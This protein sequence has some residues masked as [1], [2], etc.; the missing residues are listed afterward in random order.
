MKKLLSLLFLVFLLTAPAY[1]QKSFDM[2]YNEAVEYYTAKQYDKA[3]KVLEAAK[4]SPGVTK[5]Q[6]AKATRLIKQCQSSKQKMSDLNLSKETI[7]ASG[8]GQR[9]SIYVTAGK[10]WEVTA[11]PLWCDTWVNDDVLFIEVSPNEEA[12]TRKGIIEVSMGKERTAYLTVNQEKRVFADCPVRIVSMP[13][14]AMITIDNDPSMLSEDFILS[15]GKHRIRLE[16]NGYERKDTTIVL[17][18]NDADGVSFVIPLSPMFS[19]VSIDVKPADG[20][21]FEAEPVVDISGNEVDLHPSI[22]KSFNVDQ[23]IS[24]YTMY[25]GDV[26]PLH[27]GQYVVKARAEGFIAQKQNIK[28]ERGKNQKLEFV[29][30]P[31]TG[32]LSVSDE[33]NAS[34]A[35]VYVDGKEVGSVPFSGVALKTGKHRVR[36]VKP[37][38]ITDDEEYEVEIFEG[39]NTEHKVSMQGYREYKLSS[40]PAYCKIYMDGVYAG[41]TPMDLIVRDGEHVLRIEKAGYFPESRIINTATDAQNSFNITLENAYPFKVMADKDSLGILI[42]KGNGRNQIVYAQNVKTPAEVQIP[43]SKQPY[44]IELKRFDSKT[45]YKGNFNFNKQARNQLKILTWAD[46]TP[47]IATNV[48]VPFKANRL[49]Y[50][51]SGVN[52]KK[53]YIRVADVS[54]API[55]LFP[56]LTTNLAKATAFWGSSLIWP[57]DPERIR[58]PD[59]SENNLKA[60]EYLNEDGTT[61]VLYNDVL[62]I[63][64]FTAIL[65]NGELRIGGAVTSFM[66]AGLSAS[67]AWYPDL[68]KLVS[69]FTHMSG[70]DMF[71][72]GEVSSRLQVVNMNVKAGV[73]VFWGQAN[74]SRP[75]KKQVNGSNYYITVPYNPGLLYSVS[76]GFTL[77]GRNSRGQNFLRVF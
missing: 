13:E 12:V 8:Q 9:D 5:D 25:D 63:P 4:K 40:D 73:Q 53:N 72:G 10:D 45:V 2:R 27:P 31:V 18:R 24:Y 52:I 66:D 49:D 70:H 6:V 17:D 62:L 22:I 64:A 46:G 36:I 29:L 20:Y 77:G 35:L 51:F 15:E 21:S 41:T 34:G 16:K 3:I 38:F 26:I 30:T 54:L 33:E 55:R 23:D 75:D 28:A 76:V 11:C 61:N 59:D 44:Q 42:T 58:Y 57:N 71:I 50:G 39:K 48:Y 69:G 37:D 60:L 43:L 19:T 32:T 56:G 65:I 68:T 67:Y 14:R 7:F 74:I 47:I 1:A